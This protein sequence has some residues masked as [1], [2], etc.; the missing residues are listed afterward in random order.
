MVCTLLRLCDFLGSQDELYKLEN[1]GW[2]VSRPT[3][4]RVTF[5]L[6]EC[7][8]IFPTRKK[9]KMKK[10]TQA[11]KTKTRKKKM[12]RNACKKRENEQHG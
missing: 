5:D 6:P 3:V 1:F 4:A 12:K 2:S 8:D 7:E 10:E 9:K 11:K